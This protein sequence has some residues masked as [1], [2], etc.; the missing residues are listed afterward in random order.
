MAFFASAAVKLSVVFLTFCLVWLALLWLAYIRTRP[1]TSSEFS[2]KRILFLTAHP[3]DEALFFGPTILTLNDQRLGN[4]IALVSI[5]TGDSEG[6]GVIRQKELQQSSHE[7]GL[8]STAVRALNNAK[9]KDGIEFWDSDDILTEL[10][11]VLEDLR[12]P[13]P[14]I[15][16]TFDADGA[17]KH[18]NHMSLLSAAALSTST[19]VYALKTKEW[20]SLFAAGWV[21]ATVL[22]TWAWQDIRSS[23]KVLFVSGPWQ[24]RQILSAAS[25]HNTQKKPWPSF[26]WRLM[27]FSVY[28]VANELKLQ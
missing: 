1:T 24:W 15:V 18:P 11:D 8:P 16:V 28:Q 7:L 6:K 13:H 12:W 14:D 3:D 2:K 20:V 22:F 27:N 23:G 26:R 10:S 5:S 17:T 4:D 21:I 9:L 19:K 25:K